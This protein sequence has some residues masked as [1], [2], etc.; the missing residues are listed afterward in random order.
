[1]VAKPKTKAARRIVAGEWVTF[2]GLSF[3]VGEAFTEDG[4]VYM[5]LGPHLS[6]FRPDER[7]KMHYED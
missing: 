2:G 4:M 3:R 1:M 5:Q 6:E 7:V